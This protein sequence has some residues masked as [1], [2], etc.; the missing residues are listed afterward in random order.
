MPA[1]ENIR[2]ER[3]CLLVAKGKH[4]AD[5]Y[6][7]AGFKASN[8]DLTSRS[9]SKL[10]K[11]DDVTLRLRELQAKEAKRLNVNV[12]LL[13]FKLEEMFKLSKR[14]KQPAAGV[15]AV[16]GMAKLLGLVVDKAE[17]EGTLRRPMREPSDVK[18]MSLDE[19]QRRF[20]PASSKMLDP[21]PNDG[22][23]AL[24]KARASL[25]GGK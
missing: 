21:K 20:A 12:D 14:T 9:A 15:G 8:P 7:Q 25:G 23:Q 16:M 17:V 2:H 1:L 18:Q 6:A 3:F 11:R 24:A 22:S 5:A 4:A 10:L 19:W 13:V